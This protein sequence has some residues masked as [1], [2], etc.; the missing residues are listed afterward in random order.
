MSGCLLWAGYRDPNGYGRSFD[1]SMRLAHSVAWELAGGTV[2]AGLELDH[3]CRRPAC[4]AVAHLEP[5]T[6]KTNMRRSSVPKLNI[7][8]AR[9]IRAL[10]AQGWTPLDIAA[11]YQISRSVVYQI[12]QGR[13]WVEE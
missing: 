9:E 3:L 7:E 11:A 4:V 13:L 1:G 12:G 8:Q 5:V 10:R 2:P 6:P